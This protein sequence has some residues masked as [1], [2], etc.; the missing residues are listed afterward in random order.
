MFSSQ[1]GHLSQAVSQ[2]HSRSY[3]SWQNWDPFQM[4]KG[5]ELQ[6]LGKRL[7]FPAAKEKKRLRESDCLYCKGLLL[8]LGSRDFSTCFHPPSVRPPAINLVFQSKQRDQSYFA[9]PLSRQLPIYL[10]LES[11]LV[12]LNVSGNISCVLPQCSFPKLA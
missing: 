1:S 2:S 8:P 5:T 9:V 4:R 12:N 10:Q 3:K 6:D 7:G 11:D